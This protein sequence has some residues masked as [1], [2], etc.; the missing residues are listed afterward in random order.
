MNRTAMKQ[1]TKRTA[2]GAVALCGMMLLAASC[3]TPKNVTMFQ[4]ATPETI[5]QMSETKQLTVEPGNKLAIV[6]K[7]KNPEVSALF[8]GSIYTSPLEK[9][10]L[11]GLAQS[12]GA[13]QNTVQVTN[14]GMTT[15]TVDK[16]G[17]IDFPMLGKI[18]VEGMTRQ[19]LAGYIKGE[20]AGR[21]MVKD[22]VVTV[23]FINAGINMLGEVSRPGRYE[24]NQDELT[25]TEALAMAGDIRLSGMRTNV[26]VFRQEADG[27]HTYVIDTT[28]AKNMMSSPAYYLQQND[29][30]YVE[31]TDL[32]KRTTTANG[33]VQN[34][35]FWL[36]IA[37]VLATLA[38]TVGIYVNK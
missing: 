26:K 17:D 18:H 31:P 27:M 8:N 16:K 30:V 23:E 28:D 22:A 24:V 33:N 20:L 14:S 25:L 3:S 37:S 36:S 29:V 7:C 34:V 38:T 2:V 10:S 1:N 19:E 32:V 35:S 9:T 6:V 12:A 21:D 5:I 15:Y 4:G 11:L 13:K